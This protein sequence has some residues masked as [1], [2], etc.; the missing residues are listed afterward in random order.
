MRLRRR[1]V[2]ATL[3]WGLVAAQPARAFDFWSDFALLGQVRD[4][5]QEHRT[6]APVDVYG[7]V[8]AANMWHASDAETFFRLEQDLATGDNAGDFYA[9]YARIPNA[10]PGVSA[11]VGR[12]FI[13]EGPGGVFVADAGKL[14]I[15]PGWPVAFTLYGGAPQYFEP[16]YSSPLISQDEILFGGNMRTTRWRGGQ[17]T[18]GYQQWE[19]DSKVLRQ[20]VSASAVQSFAT[21]WASPQFFA[22]FGYDADRQN[23]DTGTAGVDMFLTRPLLLLN[24]SSTYYQPQ[25]NTDDLPDLD[26]QEDSVFQLFSDSRLVQARGAVRRPFSRALSAYVDF[27]YQN[28]EN[29]V[30]KDQNGYLANAGVLWLPEGD[31]L[32]EVLLAYFLADSPGGNLNGI[33]FFYEN[34]VYERIVFRFRTD[35]AYYEKESNQKDWP[36]H[37]QTGL[38][39]DITPDLC[40]QLIFEANRNV[41][42]D[43][44]FRFGFALTYNF[45][46]R[47]ERSDAPAEPS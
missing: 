25:D 28:Y 18:L 38:G 5:Y 9:G 36:V 40:G 35:V 43:A 32:E 37:T 7:N 44:D 39:Y 8:G 34:R 45:R 11:T 29:A 46:H 3:L 23:V 20:L 31:G 15:D 30:G 22:T 26:W 19:R 4:D 10:L 14:R 17:L 33:S 42:F 6:E 12:Q 47:F 13:N 1:L 2:G 21:W 24:F 41:L 16:T 27:S